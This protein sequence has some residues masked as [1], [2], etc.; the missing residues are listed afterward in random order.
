MKNRKLLLC[1]GV[2]AFVGGSGIGLLSH[3]LADAKI[4]GSGSGFSTVRAPATGGNL[5]QLPPTVGTSGFFLQTDGAGITTWA[6]PT[7]SA[8]S[9]TPGTTTIVGAT[10][11]CFIQN[12]TSTTMACVGVPATP[13]TT[14]T[15]VTL[16]GPRAY[17][18]CTGTCTVTLPVPVAG[19]EFCIRNDDNISTVITLAALGSSARY[20]LP[21]RM[22]YGTAGTGTAVAGGSV[23][24]QICL[25]GKD[26]THY[27]VMSST[28]TWTM[29]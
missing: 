26:S 25:L 1:F 11:P 20:E 2:A 12:S 4:E 22:S 23:T 8:S 5:F 3:A 28:G 29:N 14:G 10:A 9:I 19:Y 21:A 18:A 17:Y 6:A 27:Y 16:T 24:D 15:N 13:T 7:A